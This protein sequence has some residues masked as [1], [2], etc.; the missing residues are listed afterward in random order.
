MVRLPEILLIA[1]FPRSGTTW[2]AQAVSAALDAPLVFEPYNWSMNPAGSPYQMRYLPAGSDDWR[3]GKVLRDALRALDVDDAKRVVVKDVHALLALGFLGDR[4]PVRSTVTLVRH[5]C[6]VAASWSGL[7]WGAGDA[8]GRLLSQPALVEGHLAAHL[9]RLEASRADPWR[10]LG[11]Y[12]GATY[13]VLTELDAQD[14]IVRH[15]DLCADPVSELARVAA[16]L[17]G[18]FDQERLVAYLAEHDRDGGESPTPFYTYRP[19]ATV[20]ER[21]RTTL[22]PVVART[23]WEACEPFGV[24]DRWYEAP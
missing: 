23:V 4:F 11:A 21:W 10:A 12:W 24:A 13:L 22:D 7:G 14:R 20:S 9:E 5:P 8:I 17:D 6:P 18:S 15:E 16:G 3:H 19:T 1:G 2:T